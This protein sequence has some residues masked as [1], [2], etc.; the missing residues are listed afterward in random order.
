MEEEINIE[1]SKGKK[2][3]IT[4]IYSVILY[5]LFLAMAVLNGLLPA[6]LI[7]TA[8]VGTLTFSIIS[9]L[10][11]MLIPSS[12][13]IIFVSVAFVISFIIVYIYGGA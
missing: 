7:V 10:I 12:K 3:K 1:I 6:N 5:N 9:G 13:K 8:F 2:F 11:S 4:F